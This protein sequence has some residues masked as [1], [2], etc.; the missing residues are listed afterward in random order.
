MHRRPAGALAEQMTQL[1]ATL[2][3]VAD[4]ALGV[5]TLVMLTQA[6]RSRCGSRWRSC[7][8]TASSCWAH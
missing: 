7:C 6:G 8:A 3:S 5:V 2:D 4:K 1:G